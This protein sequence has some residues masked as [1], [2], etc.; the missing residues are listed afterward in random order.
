M[1]M[2]NKAEQTHPFYV[3]LLTAVVSFFCVLK[4]VNAYLAAG[5]V[6]DGEGGPLAVL[7]AVTILI[8]FGLGILFKKKVFSNISK[9][10]LAIILWILIFYFITIS[11][12][13]EPYTSFAFLLVFTI[14]ALLMP[15]LTFVDGR[16]FMKFMMLYPVPAIFKLDEIFV[17]PSLFRTT[18]TMGTSYAFLTPVI[19]TIVYLSTY[20]KEESWAQKLITVSLSAIN[21]V[22]ASYLL[23]FGSRGPVLAIIA[24]IVFLLVVRPSDAGVGL[25]F[26]KRNLFILLFIA[27]VASVMFVTLLNVFQKELENLGL[28]FNFIDKFLRLNDESDMTNGRT[29]LYKMAIGDF[30]ASPVWGKGFDLFGSNH[31]TTDANYPHNFILQILSDGGLL[32]LLVL[33]VPIIRGIVKICKSCSKDEY[34]VF[35]TLLLG[36]VPGAMFT[37]DL[38]RNVTLW[39][40]FGMVVSKNFVSK[41]L[42]TN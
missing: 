40:F 36:S 5:A 34:T 20:F 35:T 2:N 33:G 25:S 42:F 8:A 29:D 27:I 1:I 9:D 37:G 12:I 16:L 19:V 14:A 10:L 26:K 24:T 17:F 41:R 6:E 4:T 7:Y 21:F 3:I 39:L 23:L 18:I 13:G 11:F 31:P 32:L 28:S 30:I 15:S 38:W 22:F